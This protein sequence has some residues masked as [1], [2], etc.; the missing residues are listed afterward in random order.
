M[1]ARRRQTLDGGDLL[2]RDLGHRGLAGAHRLAV[3]MDRARAAQSGAAT[4][5]GAGEFQVLPHH[6][7]QRRVGVDLDALS[8]AIDRKRD[9]HSVSLHWQMMTRAGRP[10]RHER[11]AIFSFGDESRRA[12]GLFPPKGIFLLKQYN[13]LAPGWAAVPCDKVSRISEAT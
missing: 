8:L 2:A 10:K 7:E 13:E 6:P 1:R 5:F 12:A 9:R 11:A 4:E 3:D